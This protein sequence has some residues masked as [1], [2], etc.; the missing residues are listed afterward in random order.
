MFILNENRQAVDL[1]TSV[2]RIKVNCGFNILEQLL[3][4]EGQFE[5][6]RTD[7]D[8]SWQLKE[9]SGLSRKLSRSFVVDKDFAGSDSEIELWHSLREAVS[10]MPKSTLS[11]IASGKHRVADIVS[12]NIRVNP[13]TEQEKRA[14]PTAGRISINL[15]LDEFAEAFA[16]TESVT[17]KSVARE[18]KNFNTFLSTHSH[19]ADR[20]IVFRQASRHCSAEKSRVE[21][22]SIFIVRKGQ[23]QSIVLRH[24]HYPILFK[25]EFMWACLSC[26]R[27]IK[28]NGCDYKYI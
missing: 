18:D 16:G 11:V 17:N 14:C 25:R 12:L 24:Y 15:T 19:G 28:A 27:Q 8:H 9:Y 4:L 22:N 23:I 6:C 20:L 26:F 7:K 2:N 5:C 1:V 3:S 21:L 10:S 13:V